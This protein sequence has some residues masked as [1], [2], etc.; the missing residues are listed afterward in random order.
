MNSQTKSTVKIV[1]FDLGGVLVNNVDSW[2][3]ALDKIDLKKHSILDNNA[4]R[5]ELSR[6]NQD[7]RT[8]KIR[9]EKYYSYVSE[10]T[11]GVYSPSD[12][13]QIFIARQIAE[14]PGIDEVVDM[15]DATGVSMGVLSNTNPVHWHDLR[16]NPN[17]D[18]FPTVGRLRNA[19]ASHLL[20]YAKPDPEIYREFERRTDFY[21]SSILFFDNHEEN[22][23]TARRLGWQAERIDP[24]DHPAGQLKR[25][26]KEYKII[27]K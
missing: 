3:D 21:G 24:K 8:G 25:Y 19:H 26:L 9:P 20:G 23:N 13:S 10:A 11:G 15:V 17:D 27:D 12:I 5:S 2:E 6:L 22:V 18:R 1:V 4:F 7:L 14:Y 16:K